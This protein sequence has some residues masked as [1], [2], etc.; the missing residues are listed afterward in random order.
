MKLFFKVFLFLFLLTNTNAFAKGNTLLEW[1][2]PATLPKDYT[3]LENDLKAAKTAEE[4]LEI[5]KIFVKNF[6]RHMLERPKFQNII[7]NSLPEDAITTLH[8]FKGVEFQP[9]FWS[10][11]SEVYIARK[12]KADDLEMHKFREIIRIKRALAIGSSPASVAA[13]QEFN[14]Y[15]QR[16]I[17]IETLQ[18]EMMVRGT[19]YSP[20]GA[21]MWAMIFG[22]GPSLTVPI[23]AFTD[24]M[25]GTV[26]GM[27]LTAAAITLSTAS[28]G[29]MIAL[30]NYQ[31]YKIRHRSLSLEEAKFLKVDRVKTYPNIDEGQ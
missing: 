18:K 1:L 9:W 28:T 5:S 17:D 12:P 10:E 31:L 21:I 26:I 23:L 16:S 22:A 30:R 14:K 20:G 11:L 4:Y 13:A 27:G 8:T 19:T 24:G 3:N 6:N 2:K 25:K 29:C 7:R 15:T